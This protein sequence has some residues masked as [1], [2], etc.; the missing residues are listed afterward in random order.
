AAGTAGRLHQPQEATPLHLI[1][2]FAGVTHDHSAHQP[3]HLIGCKELP[4]A[5]V[6]HVEHHERAAK[7]IAE[8]ASGNTLIPALDQQRESVSQALQVYFDVAANDLQVA[9]L[10]LFELTPIYGVGQVERTHLRPVEPRTIQAVRG[11][12][13]PE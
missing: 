8:F 4:R 2:E 10:A 7:D 3:R 12:Q 5:G 9:L 11:G 13:V 6:S 1:G